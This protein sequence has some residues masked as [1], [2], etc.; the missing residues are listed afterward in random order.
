MIKENVLQDNCPMTNYAIWHSVYVVLERIAAIAICCQIWSFGNN[1]VYGGRKCFIH[2]RLVIIGTL[3]LVDKLVITNKRSSRFG[4]D[5]L[6]MIV[7]LLREPI[8]KTRLSSWTPLLDTNV[9]CILIYLLL[10]IWLFQYQIFHLNALF[11]HKIMNL[12]C[13]T[14]FPVRFT[15]E[16]LVGVIRDL[17]G[18]GV[19]GDCGTSWSWM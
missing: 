14:S 10:I 17:L 1:I 3:Q 9:P 15:E 6:K 13:L 4:Y 7:I 8:S 2:A 19:V 16:I 18:F 12:S 5:L 11:Q